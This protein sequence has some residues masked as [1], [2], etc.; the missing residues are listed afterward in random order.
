MAPCHPPPVV[1]QVCRKIRLSIQTSAEVR[2]SARV[3]P[4]YRINRLCAVCGTS[5]CDRLGHA[6]ETAKAVPSRH[7][8]AVIPD[9]SEESLPSIPVRMVVPPPGRQ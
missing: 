9:V 2:S 5:V 1:A 3:T 7:Q 6:P 4:V 8:V